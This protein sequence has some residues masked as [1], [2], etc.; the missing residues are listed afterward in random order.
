MCSFIPF[1]EARPEEKETVWLYNEDNNF[2]A[3]GCRVWIDGEGWFWAISN[4]VIYAENGKIVLE[5]EFDDN[6]EFT[7]WSRL[8]D[9]P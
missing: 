6:Y 8:P 4:G 7:H 9:L 2:V 3:L 1:T 5:C